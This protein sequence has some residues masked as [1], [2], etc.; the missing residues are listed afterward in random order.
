MSKIRFACVAFGVCFAISA[1]AQ[2]PTIIKEIDQLESQRDP[3]CYATANRLEDFIYGTSLDFDARAEKIALQKR[4]IRDVWI[5]ATDASKGKTQI[6]VNELRPVLQAAVPYVTT[7]GGDWI[8]LPDD[9]RRTEIS[10]RDKRQY[11]AVAYALRAILSVQQDAFV[12]GTNLLPLDEK[13]VELFKESVDLITLAALQHADRDTR[14]KNVHQ[15]NGAEMKAAWAGI[16]GTSKPAVASHAAAAKSGEKFA[17]IKSIVA[18]KLSAF[19]KYNDLSNAVFSR[20]VQVYMARHMWPSDAEDGT[21]F[22]KQFTETMV[23]WT[24]DVMLEAEKRAKKRGHPLIRIDDVHDAVQMYEPHVLNEYEDCIYFPRLPKSDQVV[25]EAYDLDAFRDPGL[26]WMYLNEVLN[27]P[28]YKGTLEPD[29]FAAELLTEGGAQM[30]T[31]ILR[32]AGKSATAANRDRLDRSDL[33]QSLRTIQALLDKNAALPPAKKVST[34]IAS[35]RSKPTTKGK[36]FTDVT[37]TSGIKF[38]HRMSDWLARLIRSYSIKETETVLAVPPAFGGSGIAAEDVNG[39][40]NIDVLVLSGSGNAL[41]LGDGKG[42]F[43]DVTESAGL[44]WKRPDG[45][46][47]EPRQPIIADFDNDGL[48]DILITY[49]DDDHRVYR[50]LGNSKFEDVT[51]RTNLGGKGLVGGPAT[52]LDFDKDGLLD[53]YIG[54]FGDYVRGVLPTFARRNTNGLPNKLFRNKGNFVFEDV[55]AGSGVD[56]TGWAQAINHLDFDGDG[57]EDLICGNDFGANA[58]Y[59]NLGDGKFEEVSSKLGTDKPSYTMN[60][61]ITDL[62]R[63][64][65]PDVYISNIVTMNKDE[66]YVLPD[67]KTRLKF[68]PQKMANMRVVEANDLWTSTAKD[69]KLV[70]YQQSQAIGRGYKSTGWSW[71]ANFFDFDNDGDDDLYLVNGMNEYAV[72]SSVNP[73]FTNSSG[74]QQQTIVP[75]AE[76]EAPVF[77]VNRNGMLE[78]QSSQSGADPAGNARAVVQ[79]DM[80]NDGALDMMVNNFNGPAMLYRNN[81]ATGNHWIKIKLTGNP[82]KGVTRDAIGATILVDTAH[83]KNLWREVFSTIGYLTSPPKEQH[84]GLGTDT[85][86]DVTVIWPNGDHQTLKGLAAD[87]T[88]RINQTTGLQK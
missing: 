33:S 21:A 5:K 63:D 38:E 82:S 40:G 68:N 60:I 15:I 49:A 71:G 46:P 35:A 3:K 67:A 69:N 12:D 43:T 47:G 19:E 56:N 14:T 24:G 13:A 85:K 42:H 84:L 58:W 59:R 83:Q 53:L 76:K 10:A 50:N 74:Q 27:D 61:G 79:F 39:D 80:D 8:I 78:E 11:G 22:K 48:P 54:Y 37:A 52:A 25:I 66:K 45:R 87:H 55:T 7:P 23:A 28:K 20:N 34:T 81:G 30:G 9:A 1:V 17:T 88:Y 18:E 65:F 77:F 51:A 57:W 44:S 31:L 86:A 72:Y 70:S 2:V 75:V 16:V 41:Y 64:G 73:Y 62:N 6:G 29:P 26:H 32:V 4:L 36:F